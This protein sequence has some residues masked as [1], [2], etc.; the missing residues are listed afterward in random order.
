MLF[1]YRS[2]LLTQLGRL[3][4]LWSLSSTVFESFAWFSNGLLSVD[5]QLLGIGLST[6]KTFQNAQ[7]RDALKKVQRHYSTVFFRIVHKIFYV[8][9]LIFI[10]LSLWQAVDQRYVGTFRLPQFPP[11]IQINFELSVTLCCYKTCLALQL[12]LYPPCSLCLPK[13]T[14]QGHWL[15]K[16]IFLERTQRQVTSGTARRIS[17]SLVNEFFIIV[18][19]LTLCF[20]ILLI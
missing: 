16:K 4:T 5:I 19:S 18:M 9:V 2:I 8:I 12:L 11:P 1:F 10:S 17:V 14:V 13:M 15:D 6:I 7:N 3:L 20:I